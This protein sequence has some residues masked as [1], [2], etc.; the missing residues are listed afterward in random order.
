ML[1]LDIDYAN[2]S[3]TLEPRGDEAATKWALKWM[4]WLQDLLLTAAFF[5]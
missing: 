1:L 3:R 5:V 2:N 4:S